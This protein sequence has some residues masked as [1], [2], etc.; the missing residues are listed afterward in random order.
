MKTI[1]TELRTALV[2][3]VCLAVV[4]CGLY[5]GLVWAL[6]QALFSDKANGSFVEIEN[7]PVGSLLIGQPFVE[8]KYFHTRPSAAGAGYDA[9][10]SSGTNLG[11]MSKKLIEDVAARVARYRQLNGLGPDVPIP[12][13]AVTASAS[14]LDPHISAANAMLQAPRVAR[15]RGMDLDDVKQKIQIYTQHRQ[16]GIFGEPR[17]NVLL[18]N[19]ALDGKLKKS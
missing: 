13:D 5:P 4:V 9:T 15:A 19:L 2:S 12:V 3:V 14:G 17:V 6:A 7:S 16:F 11:P 1:I 18:L 10:N 8:P